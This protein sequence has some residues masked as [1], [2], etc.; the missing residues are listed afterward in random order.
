MVQVS[1]RP[2]V[3]SSLV[4][5]AITTTKGPTNIIHKIASRSE[6]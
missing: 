6:V 5:Y 4:R 1:T 3:D 2:L